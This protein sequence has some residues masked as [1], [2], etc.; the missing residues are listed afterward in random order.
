MNKFTIGLLPFMFII[1]F[2]ILVLIFAPIV[3]IWSLNTL[4]GLAIPITFDTWIA[5]FVLSVILGS[6]RI[7]YQGKK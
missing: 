4:F 2:V 5:A 7:G 6:P 1:S 3:G